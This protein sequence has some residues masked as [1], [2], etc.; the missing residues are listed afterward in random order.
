MLK[1][2][3]NS[4]RKQKIEIGIIV[5]DYNHPEETLLF[6]KQLQ[7]Q[8]IKN[9]KIIVVA[10]GSNNKSINI[11][12][13]SKMDFKLLEIEKN[14]GWTGGVNNGAKYL[15]KKYDTKYLLICS[16]DLIIDKN[17]INFLIDSIKDEENV[18]AVGPKVYYQS[19]KDVFYSAGMKL[20]YPLFFP[21]RLPLK[22]KRDKGQI[23]KDIYV[24]WVDDVL[25]I[26]RADI[27][28]EIGM[29]DEDYFMYVEETDLSYRIVKRGYKIKIC[30]NATVW[31]KGHGT[32]GG[33]DRVAGTYINSFV[34]YYLVRN[35]I[36]FFRKNISVVFF[37]F[38]LIHISIFFIIQTISAIRRKKYN[39]IHSML[40]GF[41]WHLKN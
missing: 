31:H 6:I 5:V 13:S 33:G 38:I 20:C 4:M 21:L 24:N 34:A 25:L 19:P 9:S 30:S 10:N 22:N 28:S 37:P 12:K 1:N 41:K 39:I 3:N 23:I 17:C 7:D 16:Y 26:I 14:N 2:K 36:L 11:L 40:D 18:A 29:H 8:A 32:S 15:E 35:R 27:F